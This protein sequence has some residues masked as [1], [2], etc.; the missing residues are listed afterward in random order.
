MNAR[1]YPRAHTQQNMWR[2]IEEKKNRGYNRRSER[3]I[4]RR[5][6]PNELVDSQMVTEYGRVKS[7]AGKKE[8]KLESTRRRRIIAVGNGTATACQ[9]KPK[10]FGSQRSMLLPCGETL[11]LVWPSGLGY[12]LH[13]PVVV[14]HYCTLYTLLLL[15]I[16]WD[17]VNDPNYGAQYHFVGFDANKCDVRSHDWTK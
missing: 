11:C 8:R 5:P 7:I 1:K 17:D 3:R 10:I 15:Y 9:P 4:L 14:P 13:D 16:V 6:S 2:M 12:I